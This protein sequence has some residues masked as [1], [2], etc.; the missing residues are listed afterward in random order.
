MEIIKS[1]VYAKVDDLGRVIAIDGGYSIGNITNFDDWIFIDEGIGDRFNLC[2]TNYADDSVLTYEGIPRY[3]LDG[4]TLVKR[5]AEEIDADRQD[6]FNAQQAIIAEQE[7]EAEQQNQLTQA[8]YTMA[9]T[10]F[11]MAAPTMDADTVISCRVLADAWKPGVYSTGDVCTY[12]SIPYHCIQ[13]HDSTGNL[14]WN[15]LDAVSLWS[16][17]H[18]HTPETAMPYRSPTGAHDMYRA[19]ECMVWTDGQTMRAV[20]DTSFSPEDYPSAWEVVS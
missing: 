6:K 12:E 15:P 10:S 2:Q 4:T 5:S 13:A 7:K 3:R 17:Y 9:R 1:K 18:G 19:G 20:S 14:S 11:R 8:V 16:S